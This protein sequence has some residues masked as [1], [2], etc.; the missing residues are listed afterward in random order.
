MVRVER[1]ERCDTGDACEVFEHDASFLFEFPIFLTT[2]REGPQEALLAGA[3]EQVATPA[4]TAS[5]RMTDLIWCPLVGAIVHIAVDAQ[6]GVRDLHGETP[7]RLRRLAGIVPL[8][9]H[10]AGG[11][12][13]IEISSDDL[14]L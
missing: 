4:P 7:D 12:T 14:S 1:V 6:L 13:I 3:D 11:R 10:S 8:L 5:T 2:P 9:N